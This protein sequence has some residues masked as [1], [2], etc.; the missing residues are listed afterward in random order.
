M[1]LN[2]LEGRL[3]HRSHPRAV[4]LAGEPV[5]VTLQRYRSYRRTEVVQSHLTDPEPVGQVLGVRQGRGQA[6]DPDTLIRVGGD[7]VG[8]RYNHFQDLENRTNISTLKIKENA[9]KAKYVMNIQIYKLSGIFL[10]FAYP[11]IKERKNT[12]WSTVLPE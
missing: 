4:V 3:I 12:Y 10:H 5:D 11:L 8:S 6:D 7:E 2:S 1:L 9:T